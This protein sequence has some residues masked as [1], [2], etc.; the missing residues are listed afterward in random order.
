MLLSSRALATWDA[1]KTLKYA[2]RVTGAVWLAAAAHHGYNA[3]AGIENRG[4]S[5]ILAAAQA[6]LGVLCLARGCR[7]AN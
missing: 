1:Q 3:H 2:L 6:V 7:P 4:N 5:V